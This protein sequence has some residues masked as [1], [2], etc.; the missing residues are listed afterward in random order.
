M[1]V[2]SQSLTEDQWNTLRD[3]PRPRSVEGQFR[4]LTSALDLGWQIEEPVYLRPRWAEG[5]PRVYHFI[6]KRHPTSPPKLITV[7]EGP[8]LRRFVADERLQVVPSPEHHHCR[9]SASNRVR[10]QSRGDASSPAP[11]SPP[12]G[13]DG[14]RLCDK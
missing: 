12:R 14:G 8:D 4:L 2:S 1:P 13:L 10:R 5:A 11:L 9:F 7:P 6:F 3:G